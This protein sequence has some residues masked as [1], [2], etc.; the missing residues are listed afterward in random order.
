[1][2]C[3]T[4]GNG[5]LLVPML[6]IS[7]RLRLPQ[8]RT[9]IALGLVVARRTAAAS[10]NG[11]HRAFITRINT[12]DPRM[13]QVVVHQPSKTVYLSGV[14]AA[15][16]GDT[17][18]LQTEEV[19]RKIDERLSLAGTNKSNLLH[20]TIWLKDIERDFK[21]MN[22][23]WN[24]WIDPDNKP[25]RATVESAMARP[26]ILVEIQATASLPQEI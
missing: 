7:S 22:S 5:T 1:M 14:T 8:A 12:E 18:S 19:L 16:A 2:D 17:V 21:E 13:S 20:C 11:S 9:N 23:V 25:C 10:L 15:A 24:A 6:H 26:A 4:D 3:E